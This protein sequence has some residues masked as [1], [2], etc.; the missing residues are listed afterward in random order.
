[1]ADGPTIISRADAAK[2]GLKHYFTSKP[3]KHGHVAER[4]TAT[5]H[6]VEC[7]REE[8]RKRYAANPERERERKRERKRERYAANPERAREQ[9]RA[10]RAANGKSA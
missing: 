1:M 6:C 7:H 8:D 3:C 2:A 10:W 5:G 9:N 4:R